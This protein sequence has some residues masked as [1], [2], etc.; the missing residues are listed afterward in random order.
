MYTCPC[1]GFYT[2]NEPA[3]SYAI[4]NICGWEDDPVQLRFPTMQKG[5]NGGSLYGYQKLILEKIPSD[6][7]V[8]K[9]IER[10]LKWRPL[11]DSDLI[12]PEKR[13]QSALDYFNS[14]AEDSPKYYWE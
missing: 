7:T 14:A 3:G 11:K 4:C 8:H 13:P 2:L 9:G 12:S 1:C 10:N 6:Q 5:A